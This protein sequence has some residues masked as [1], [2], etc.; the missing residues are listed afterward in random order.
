L[1]VLL[2]EIAFVENAVAQYRSL[3]GHLRSANEAKCVA[4]DT[5]V[6][7]AKALMTAPAP[8]HGG[9]QV[10]AAY[11]AA[12]NTQ[13]AQ[14]PLV[15]AVFGAGTY[16]QAVQKEYTLAWECPSPAASSRACPQRMYACVNEAAFRC[17]LSLAQD[18]TF[19]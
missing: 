8:L 13:C 2:K 12:Y 3:L 9:N 6:A 10:R 19:M 17:A 7:M 15:D 5:L 4:D 18:A 1:K 11:S 16:G 14:R